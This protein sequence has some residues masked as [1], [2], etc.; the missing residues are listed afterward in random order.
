MGEQPS[1]VAA[2]AACADYSSDA[3]A[4]QSPSPCHVCVS[5]APLELHVVVVWVASNVPGSRE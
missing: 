4:G 2:S 3:M 5:A 1:A